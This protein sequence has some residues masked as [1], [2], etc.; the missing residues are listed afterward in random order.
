MMSSKVA[1]LSD[2]DL[3]GALTHATYS[4]PQDMKDI[5]NKVCLRWQVAFSALH[6]AATA[7]AS[8]QAVPQHVVTGKTAAQLKLDKPAKFEGDSKELANW[9]FNL[10][11]NC[12]VC[13]IMNITEQVKVAMTFLSGQTLMWQRAVACAN[14]ATLG[15]CSWVDFSQHITMEFQD[16]HNQLHNSTKLF[17]LYQQGA[18]AKYN[19]EFRSLML[20]VRHDMLAQDI[21]MAYLRGLKP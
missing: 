12:M 11:Q 17:D 1:H 8:A 19:E 7:S 21:F 20:E 13:S 4:A 6:T 18:V 9:I 10:E 14:W 5:F 15:I 3:Y 2:Q 16:A